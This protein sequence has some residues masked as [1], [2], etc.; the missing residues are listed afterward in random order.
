MIQ[1]RSTRRVPF[2]RGLIAET[3]V[4]P[5][6]YQLLNDTHSFI[7]LKTEKVVIEDA[8][9]NPQPTMRVRGLFQE[10]DKDNANQRWYERSIL[11]EAASLIQDDISRRG[12]LGEFDHPPDAK[13]HLDRICHLITKIWMD[14]PRVFGEAEVLD[15]QVHGRALRGLFESKI[16]IGIS[17]RGIGDMELREHNGKQLYFVLPGYQFVTWDVVADP[18]VK[19]AYL[20]PIKESINR[21]QRAT[22]EARRAGKLSNEAYEAL[23]LEEVN[24]LFG[25][26]P[27]LPTR[28][29]RR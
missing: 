6:G 13:I 18:S 25:I 23:L 1:S 27:I 24:K 19:G 16:R 8:N 11:G 10:A 17:S 5:A 20:Q 4:I 22:S 26:K 14:G 15:N 7:P 3:G 21:V 29:S 2:N 12:V 28:R 9:G